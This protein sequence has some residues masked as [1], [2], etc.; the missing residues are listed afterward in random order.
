MPP[1]MHSVRTGA[2]RSLLPLAGPVIGS[3]GDAFVIA[4]WQDAGGLA[5]APRLVAPA[6]SITVTMK[7][8]MCLRGVLR[9]QVRKDEIEAGYRPIGFRAAQNAAYLLE[10]GP[11]TSPLSAESADRYSRSSPGNSPDG[12]VLSRGRAGSIHQV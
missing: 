10:C 1:A 3:T 2:L 6:T 9:V 11:G 8:G 12:G 4:E 7:R 5:G